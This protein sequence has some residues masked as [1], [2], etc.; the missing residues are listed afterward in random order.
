[1]KLKLIISSITIAFLIAGCASDQAHRYYLDQ[2]LTPKAPDQV[3]ILWTP[4]V[5]PYTLIADF[6]SRGES[7]VDMQ[8]RAAELG[9][10]AVIV[11]PLGGLVLKDQQYANS[12]ALYN[13]PSQ[14]QLF[15]R[16]TASAIIYQK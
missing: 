13:Q 3:E 1:M 11:T 16:I 7:A 2:K 14:T 12:S 4:P 10:D 5:R 15:Q 6:Q 9:A 8:K